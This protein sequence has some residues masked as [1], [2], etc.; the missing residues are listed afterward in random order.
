MRRLRS[1]S[2]ELALTLGVLVAGAPG[3]AWAQACCAGSGALTPGRLAMHEQALV[4][5]ELRAASVYGSFDGRGH[6]ATPPAGANEQDF[7]EDVFGAVRFLRRGQAA[8]FVPFL[9]TRRQTRSLGAEIGGGVGDVN[10]SARWD[11]IDAGRYQVMPGV[12][13]LAGITFPTGTAPDAATNPQATDA[14]GIGA[15]QGNV[16][17]ALEQ[18]FGAWLFNATLLAAKRTP[19]EAQ[20]VRTTLGTQWTTLAAVAYAFPDDSALA[21]V[22][23]YMFEGDATIGGHDAPDSGR[24][25]LRLNLSGT[26]PLS[27]RLRLQAS[28]GF[29]PPIPH[30]GQNQNPSV[31][32]LFAVLFSWS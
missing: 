11:F 16:G 21:F 24:R 22:A 12:G 10:L 27:D 19:R 4:G 8:L 32:L 5:A 29:D 2:R 20:G 13:L 17:I 23:S 1:R 30:V 25:L 6:Y 3:A 26:H 31:S 9:E 18:T 15:F 7:E 14:T 28:A